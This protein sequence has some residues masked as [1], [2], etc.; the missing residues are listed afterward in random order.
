[1]MSNRAKLPIKLVSM[2]RMSG[3]RWRN[4]EMCSGLSRGT[5]A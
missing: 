3:K 2:D 1:M 4:N 5:A